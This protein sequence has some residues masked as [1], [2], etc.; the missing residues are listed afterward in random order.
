MQSLVF[1]TYF[2]KSYQRKTF[3]ES[4]LSPCLGKGS[5]ISERTLTRPPSLPSPKSA[6]GII[7]RAKE[8]KF[9]QFFETN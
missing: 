8:N 6:L 5:V 1:L 9:S 7:R 4:T 3:G 2:F